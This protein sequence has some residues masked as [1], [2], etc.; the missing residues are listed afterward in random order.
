MTGLPYALVGGGPRSGIGGLHRAAAGAAGLRLVAGCFSGDPQR[1]LGDGAALS[2]D[3]VRVH[4]NVEALVRAETA[5]PDGARLLVVAT[6]HALHAAALRVAL[7]HGWRVLV[8]KPL[9]A[10][11]EEA[12]ALQAL[13]AAAEQPLPQVAVALEMRY[14]PGLQQ[15][16][17]QLADGVIGK[18]RW[19]S[20]EYLQGRERFEPHA[21]GDWRFQP[22]LAGPAGT[23]A[24]LGP[25]AI[26]L[27]HWLTGAELGLRAADVRTLHP[28]HALD[29][30]AWLW[31]DVGPEV[32]AQLTLCQAATGLTAHCVVRAFG[33]RGVLEWRLSDESAAAGGAEAL[34]ASAFHALY[35]QVARW[36][37]GAFAW[38]PE[39]PGWA[40]GLRA[41]RLAHA[42]LA[43]QH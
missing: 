13:A 4:D 27:C 12:E 30:S 42:A 22:A 39:L 18:L 37:V 21:E 38:P 31:L 43:Q 34:Y 19:L 8:D 20:I 35:F 17:R 7:Q 26:D 6:P 15:L 14:F 24:D 25:H 11:P 5:R 40:D 10:W 16:R 2:L 23:L 32:R 3:R 41:L 28:A 1:N 9:C 36:H 29:D 33:S